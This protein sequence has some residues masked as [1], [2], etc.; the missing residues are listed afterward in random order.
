MTSS[1]NSGSGRFGASSFFESTFDYR[2]LLPTTTSSSGPPS[3]VDDNTDVDESSSLCYEMSLR[4]RLL[5]CGTCMVAGYMLSMGSFW[6][7]TDLVVRHD[8]FPFVLHATGTYAGTTSHKRAV[9]YT[10][11]LHLCLN[12]LLLIILALSLF[13][14]YSRQLFGLG[15]LF[16]SHG[17]QGTMES[18]VAAVPTNC[19]GHVS[20]FARFD[21]LGGIFLFAHLGS[22]GIVFAPFDD[23][24]IRC[25]Y[26]VYSVVYPFCA[27]CLEELF[28]T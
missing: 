6:R 10:E 18:H 9:S 25:H 16:L 7:I 12:C 27:R 26:V 3:A 22:Q 11:I 24:S 23:L 2:S 28:A 15:G 8:P 5:G 19:N 4:E 20:R 1:N 13:S 21:P 14:I 17:T